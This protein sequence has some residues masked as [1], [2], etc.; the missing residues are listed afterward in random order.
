MKSIAS[1]ASI[2]GNTPHMTPAQAERISSFILENRIRDILELGFRHGVST[3]YM[4]TTLARAGEGRIVTIDLTS[5][6]HNKPN[7]EELLNQVGERSRVDVF[8]EPTSYTWRLMRMLQQDPTPLFDH[9]Y[10]GGAHDWFVDGLAFFLADRQLQPNGWI[11]FDD[12]DW[13]YGTSTALS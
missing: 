11:V 7:V 9:W 4:A 2:V 12:M 3:T 5:A 6:K 1:V 13:P 10:N 8:Y